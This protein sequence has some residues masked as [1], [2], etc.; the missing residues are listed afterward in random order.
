MI[1]F[2]S[3]TIT[4]LLDYLCQ[5]VDMTPLHSDANIRP[6][7]VSQR[8]GRTLVMILTNTNNKGTLTGLC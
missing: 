7:W 1:R 5:L 2:S 6:T 8:H 4:R 3:I